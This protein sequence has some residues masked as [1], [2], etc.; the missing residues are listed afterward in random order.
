[1]GHKIHPTGLRLGITQ[2]HRSRWYASSKTYPTL[3]QEDDRIR[4]FIHKKYGSAGIS[5]VLIARKA[6]Q[7]EVELKTARPGVLVGRQGSGIEDLRAGIQKTVGD[8]SR[9]V[10]INV[11]EVERVDGDAF[12]LAEY[13]AQQLEK[14]VAFRRTMRMAVQRAQRAGV[15]GLKIQ[16]SGRLNGAEI[17]R[18][19][20]TREGRVPLHTLRAD[21][22]Y[23]IKVGKTTYGVLGIKVWVFK[24]EVLSEQSQTMPVGANPRRRAS[25]RPQQFEDRSN[26]G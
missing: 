4:K 11:V 1:M 22:D 17:A 6:D 2:E 15:L 13:I 7:L 26:E 9:Q 18:T 19:E 8:K 21:I 24:G 3:L 12:L 5:D 25:R 20:W 23:A 10:R 16:V 14:R